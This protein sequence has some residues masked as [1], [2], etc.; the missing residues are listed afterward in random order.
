MPK[1]NLPENISKLKINLDKGNNLVDYFVICGVNPSICLDE[2]LYNTENSDY[3]AKKEIKPEILSKCPNFDKS[4][5]SIDEGILNYCFPKGFKIIY[6]RKQPNM[7]YFS[8]ILDNNLYSFDHPQK[9]VTCLLFYECIKKYKDLKNKIENKTDPI[10]MLDDNISEMT[11]LTEIHNKK[12]DF[13]ED[14]KTNINNNNLKIKQ[15]NKK[16]VNKIKYF[17]IPKCICLISI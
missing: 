8:F 3:L 9:Y 1:Q 6:T 5:I 15:I 12:N 2:T 7:E 14:N 17:Y 4:I 13:L 16:V 10:T 11:T